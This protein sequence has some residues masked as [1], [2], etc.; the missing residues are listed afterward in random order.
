MRPASRITWTSDATFSSV[1]VT[2]PAAC[3]IFSSTTVPWMSLAPKWSA[4]WASGVEIMIQ[5]AFTCS[6]LSSM[7]R[8]TAIIFRSSMPVV[9]F[10]PRRSK[11]VFS[12]WN[13]SGMNA[14]KPS[15]SS[16]RSRSV[17]R[18]SMRSS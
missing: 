4:T 1:G 17:S 5:Y 18:C 9:C 16:W 3:A 7:R 11:T 10:Q 8:D 12:G 6:M 2:A 14:M 15:V 13:G